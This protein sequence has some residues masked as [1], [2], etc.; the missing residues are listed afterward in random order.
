MKLL[1]HPSL[2]LALAL[3]I[4]AY[5]RLNIPNDVNLPPVR[6]GLAHKDLAPRDDTYDQAVERGQD[7]LTQLSSNRYSAPITG[8]D[9]A[10]SGF[11]GW[12]I[13]SIPPPWGST[14]A[15]TLKVVLEDLVGRLKNQ[16]YE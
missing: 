14:P 16:Y 7:F 1:N 15:V 10:D 3:V 4:R 8:G 12:K 2:L 9:I 11:Q 6:N 5:S 13:K